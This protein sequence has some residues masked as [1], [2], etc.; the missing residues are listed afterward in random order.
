MG[1]RRGEELIVRKIERGT[2]IDH[3][4][5]GR[6]LQVLKI[7]GI[8]GKEGLRV[9]VVMNVESRKL[10]K[11]DIVKV[12]GL[13]LRKEQ[14]DL[15]SLIAPRATI[16]IIKDYRVI[17]KY[18]VEV[19]SKIEGLLKCTNPNC[20]TNQPREPVKTIF[21]LVSTNPLTLVCEYCGFRMGWD[22]IA[23]QFESR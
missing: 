13:E 19:P 12:E 6:A 23:K 1:E 18:R 8:T 20:I 17:S 21:R 15:I 10:G 16:N 7:L 14:V 22:D 9:A 11:K 3:I 2:V 5:A 4:E